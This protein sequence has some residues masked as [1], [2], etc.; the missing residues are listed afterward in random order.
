[1]LL[2]DKRKIMLLMKEHWYSNESIVY[3]KRKKV[4]LFQ[5]VLL[6]IH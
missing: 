4:G 1:M 2:E 3:T 6:F 5:L